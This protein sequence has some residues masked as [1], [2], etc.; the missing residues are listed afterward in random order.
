M[1]TAL[2]ATSPVAMAEESDTSKVDTDS[3]SWSIAY[4]GPNPAGSNLSEVIEN[5]TFDTIMAPIVLKSTKSEKENIETSEKIFLDR[6]PSY[7]SDIFTNN[8]VRLGIENF[9]SNI[10]ETIEKNA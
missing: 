7:D 5:I 4:N 2:T 3:S 9:P 8:P 10:Q 1:A 6:A